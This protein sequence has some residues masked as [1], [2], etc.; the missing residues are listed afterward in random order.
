[1]IP[2]Y[3]FAIIAFILLGLQKINAVVFLIISGAYAAFTEWQWMKHYSFSLVVLM[4]FIYHVIIIVAIYVE[5]VPESL[6]QKRLAQ[7][8]EEDLWKDK[9]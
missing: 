3:L 8:E 2:G 7:K 6:K 4:L 1:M 5:E 9:I